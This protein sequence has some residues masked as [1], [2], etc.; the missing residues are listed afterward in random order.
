[1]QQDIP[2]LTTSISADQVSAFLRSHP[3]FFEEHASLLAEIFLPSPHGGGAISLVERQQL[4]Q[5]DKIR[6]TEVMLAKLIEF[7]EQNDI[8]SNKVHRFSLK[9]LE[10]NGINQLQA[11]I[12]TSMQQDFAVT[13]SAIRVWVKPSDDTL[14]QDAI[15]AS[16]N[17]D[18]S[19]WIASLT[20]PSC[21]QKSA[22]DDVLSTANL[23]SFAYIPLH[24]KTDKSQPIGVLML[25][26][27]DP[28]RFKAD[29]G[30]MYLKRIGELVSAELACYV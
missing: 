3:S 13:Q 1:M 14:S 18:F 24:Q 2:A 19:N 9:L 23:Q 12:S 26:S 6:V 5:R 7:G 16:V 17:N 27:E 15:F 8:T 4:A 21:G 28:Q 10:N 11:M 30:K 25:A 20:E 29:D 22:L